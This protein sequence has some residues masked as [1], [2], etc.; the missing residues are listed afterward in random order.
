MSFATVKLCAVSL[1]DWA[2]GTGHQGVM[3]EGKLINSLNDL[4]QG[5]VNQGNLGNWISTQY[6]YDQFKGLT[7]STCRD[8]KELTPTYQDSGNGSYII[9]LKSINHVWINLIDPNGKRYSVGLGGPVSY[10]YI[11]QKGRLFSPDKREL[12]GNPHQETRI[13]VT[14]E[15]FEKVKKAIEKENSHKDVCYTYI[16]RNCIQFVSDVLRETLDLDIP[17]KE[18]VD[19]ILGRVVLKKLNLSPPEAVL[20]LIDKI[21]SIIRPLFLAPL[22]LLYFATG[23][24]YTP[25]NLLASR[26]HLKKQLTFQERFRHVMT[27]DFMRIPTYVKF[28]N[29]QERARKQFPNRNMITLEEA[30]S[31]HCPRTGIVN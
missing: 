24:W 16:D 22:G 7:K 4:P 2:K 23:S 10:P 20:R 28:E 31:V 1:E 5:V 9:S 29:W 30:K 15:Q 19:E 8:W 13:E 27:G 18:S 6:R 12:E 25:K 21:A 26:N 14:Q 3:Y 11:A 17:H